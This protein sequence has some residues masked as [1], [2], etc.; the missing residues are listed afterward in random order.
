MHART[1][2]LLANKHYRLI[3]SIDLFIYIQSFSTHHTGLF[4]GSLLTSL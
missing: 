2:W 3:K 4:K 1:Q